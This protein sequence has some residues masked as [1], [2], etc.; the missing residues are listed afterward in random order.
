MVTKVL[1]Q[2]YHISA[3]LKSKMLLVGPSLVL[4]STTIQKTQNCV[5]LRSSVRGQENHAT[6]YALSSKAGICYTTEMGR[7]G[8]ISDLR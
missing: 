2:A 6:L 7:S 4:S 3:V 8:R 5:D 1:L